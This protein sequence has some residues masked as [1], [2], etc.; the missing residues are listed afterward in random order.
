MQWLALIKGL[1][2]AFNLISEYFRNKQLIDAGVNKEKAENAEFIQ[3][4]AI[5]ANH[6][7]STEPKRKFLYEP[8]K[9]KGD[10]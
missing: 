8:I 3:K 10:N 7:R 4:E 6:I 9:R 1:L 2:K 5:E